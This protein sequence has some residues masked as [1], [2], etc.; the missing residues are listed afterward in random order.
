MK[1]LAGYFFI[2]FLFVTSGFAQSPFSPEIDSLI[3]RGIDQ[4]FVCAFSEAT[5]TFADIVDRYPDHYVG[6]FYQA[7]TLQSMMMD[8][9]GPYWETEFY[10][11][12][13]RSIHL[14]EASIE[15]DEED[16]W[17]HFYLGS[18]HT[19]KALYL[20]KA[21]GLIS[22][23]KSARLG[24]EH[25]NRAVELDSSLYDA[26]LGIGSYKYWSG[27]FKKYFK[28]LPW[29]KDEREEGIL[30]VMLA[31]NRGTF[32]RWVG[33]NGLAWIEYDKKEYD[34]ALQHFLMGLE[35]YPNSRFFLWGTADTYFR[36]EIFDEAAVLYENL[37]VDI[38]SVTVNNGYNE[39]VCRYKLV[40]TY[41]AQQKYQEALRHCE[42]ILKRS[43]DP[44]VEKRVKSRIKDAGKYR[45]RCVD[46]MG[47]G[48]GG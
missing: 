20:V 6:Y 41:F 47:G 37:L 2:Q 22:G 12:I 15:R 34:K 9:E 33:I 1:R 36:M 39:I 46:R 24:L 10:G 19:Y 18:A 43:V 35:K 44:W 21:G 7:A 27:R 40:K 42:A 17:A 38:Q 28:W 31:V 3:L 45:D 25:L 23:L 13:D 16:A 14:A 48:I 8:Y 29:V 26:Y 5:L 30:L 11:L 4:T 32:S